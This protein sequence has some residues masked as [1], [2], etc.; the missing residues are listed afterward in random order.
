M[1][2]KCH[3]GACTASRGYSGE[4]F[5]GGGNQVRRDIRG[6]RGRP[7]GPSCNHASLLDYAPYLTLPDPVSGTFSGSISHVHFLF[8]EGMTGICVKY[9]IHVFVMA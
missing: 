4:E 6:P 7:A 8:F 1:D 5:A 9:V 2:Q 3:I